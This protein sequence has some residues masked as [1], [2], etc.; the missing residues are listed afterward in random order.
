MH[1]FPAFCFVHMCSGRCSIQLL[2]CW[3][4]YTL[5]QKLKLCTNL[6]PLFTF[7]REYFLSIFYSTNTFL[8]TLFPCCAPSTL[9]LPFPAGSLAVLFSF[10]LSLKLHPDFPRV[11]SCYPEDMGS[12]TLGKKSVNF[13]QTAECHIPGDNIPL[14]SISRIGKISIN[15]LLFLQRYSIW[16]Q[17]PQRNKLVRFQNFCS[18]VQLNFSLIKYVCN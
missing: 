14:N 8:F 10:L 11:F 18:T 17:Q 9:T 1:F 5:I 4:L 12:R 3:V 13:Y 7:P 15:K 6:S 16:I 2:T